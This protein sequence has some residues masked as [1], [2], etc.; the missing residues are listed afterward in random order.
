MGEQFKVL[1]IDDDESIRTTTSAILENEGYDVDTAENGKEAIEKSKAGLYKV[2]LIDFRLPDMN[3]TELLTTLKETIPRMVKIIVT[4]YPTLQNAIE[5]VN[6]HA[7]AYF[8]K[9]VDYESLL[10]TIKTLIKKQK[11]GT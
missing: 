2:A 3:G 7:D 6:K 1:V 11:K 8:T 9:P 4:G 10:K 5:C